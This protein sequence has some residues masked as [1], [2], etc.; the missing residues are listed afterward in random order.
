MTTQ[1]VF[2]QGGGEGAHDADSALAA[3]LRRRLGP[4]YAV[5]FPKMPNEGEPE[6]AAWKPRI[7]EEIARIDGDLILVG[8]SVGAYMLV[9]YLSED[10]TPKQPIGIFLIAAPYPDGDENWH[11]PGFSLPPHFG[12]KLP[13]AA[14]IFLYHSPDDQSV[15]F[16]HMRLYARAMPGAVVRET[17]GGHQLNNDLS[18]IATDM[19]GL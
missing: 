3:S 16:A 6:Y 18:V 2:I 13:D 1:V 15:P 9:K 5:S 19:H 11:F 4:R 17:T 8:H 14:R 12:A 10:G 7:T